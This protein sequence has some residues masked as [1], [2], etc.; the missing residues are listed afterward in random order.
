M[1][2]ATQMLDNIAGGRLGQKF[3]NCDEPQR[4]EEKGGEGEGGEGRRK[5]R[6]QGKAGIHV[7]AMVDNVTG[8]RLGNMGRA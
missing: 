1:T 5:G 2:H 4:M 6:R 8:Y 3:G 7:T